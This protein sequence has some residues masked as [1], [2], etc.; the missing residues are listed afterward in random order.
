MAAQVLV[1]NCRL[2]IARRGGWSWG[3][4][5]AALLRGVLLRLP[6]L[7]AARL[8]QAW[9][10]DA[11]L[12]LSQP[13]RLRLRVSRQ[14]LAA[15]A[16]TGAA[17]AA[18]PA[19]ASTQALLQR[20]DAE[21]QAWAA[22]VA[23]APARAATPLLPA[24][25]A[26]SAAVLP[27]QP[28][29]SAVLAVLAAWH[30]RNALISQLLAFSQAALS[31][32]HAALLHARAPARPGGG[33]APSRSAIT[34]FA[35]DAAALM[36]PVPASLRARL[37][38][39]IACM[40]QAADALGVDCGDPR[41]LDAMASHAQLALAEQDAPALEP[42]PLEAAQDATT[43]RARNGAAPASPRDAAIVAAATVLADRRPT[44]VEVSCALPFLL[45]GPL[46]RTGYLLA[47]RATFEAA[48]IAGLLPWFAFALARKVL[49][50]PRRGWLHDAQALRSARAFAG[51]T[52]EVADDPL[53]E[54]ARLLPPHLAP[55]D[56]TVADVLARGHE[57][58]RPLV[59]REAG[60]G[61]LLL[62]A[63]GL[64]AI[65]WAERI[66]QLFAR[67]APLREEIV[68]L[69][70]GPAAATAMQALDEAGFRFVSDA[71][72]GRGQCWRAL[73]AAQQRFTSNDRSAGDAP[74]LAAAQRLNGLA[75]NVDALW[76]AFL[77]QRPALPPDATPA[78]ERSL[79]LAAA[80]GAG[81][82]AWTL[83]HARGPVTPL[84][85]PER[86]ADLGALVHIRDETIEVKLPLGRRF[87]DLEAA[88]LLA[89]VADVPWFGGRPLRFARG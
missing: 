77:T 86:F 59:L 53:A 4:D 38:R 26:P 50:P 27:S 88:G 60:S 40:V 6:Q 34:A 10:D 22:H 63:D 62:E 61:W 33:A 84:L 44:Q 5:P 89:D 79:A 12:V 65:A 14:E 13:V 82:I 56:A 70:D 49:A 48:G 45:L 83:W 41:V 67:L 71:A 16:A 20:I 72:A 57:P 8:G 68:L 17:D 69:P 58:G 43:A 3:P 19:A 37:V 36:V 54:L 1:R 80:L 32:W 2:R 75:E 55:L 85:A 7:L 25:E 30:R 35:A 73:H 76:Q 15:L 31:D 46:A 11:D 42:A 81:T 18:T 23:P 39:R 66:E 64:F 51:W 52:D 78:V 87:L 21:V 24:P 28:R 47:L 74:L 29:G 9:P